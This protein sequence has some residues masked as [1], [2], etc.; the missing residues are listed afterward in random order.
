MV[1]TGVVVAGLAG[2]GFTRISVVISMLVTPAAMTDMTVMIVEGDDQCR[3]RGSGRPVDVAITVRKPEV[4]RP[5]E[6]DR[7]HHD[8]PDQS[9]PEAATLAD[10]P[11]DPT[12]TTRRGFCPGGRESV[13]LWA[14]SSHL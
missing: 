8:R 4:E 1:V 13:V 9:M 10:R 14:L 11:L 2:R 5:A 7:Q 3:G 6:S 12:H